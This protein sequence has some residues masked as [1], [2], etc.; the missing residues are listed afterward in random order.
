MAD[1]PSG[2]ALIILFARWRSSVR[3]KITS[4]L[5]AF[6]FIEV[7]RV[8]NWPVIVTNRLSTHNLRHYRYK[9]AKNKDKLETI[10]EIYSQE[11][12]SQSKGYPATSRLPSSANDKNE[13]ELFKSISVYKL[14]TL[15]SSV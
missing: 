3:S 10:K 13:L 9:R 12:Y 14:D 8:I 15:S 6:R 11:N 2:G 4:G 7:Y 5:S 1:S